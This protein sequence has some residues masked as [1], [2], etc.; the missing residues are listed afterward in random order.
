VL[1][2]KSLVYPKL[3]KIFFMQQNQKKGSLSLQKKA[4]AKLLTVPVGGVYLPPTTLPV[5]VVV[6]CKVHPKDQ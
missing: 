4:I 6:F 3:V 5:S 2:V 1:V